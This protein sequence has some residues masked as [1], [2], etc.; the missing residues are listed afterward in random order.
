VPAGVT[1]DPRKAVVR[2]TAFDEAL[3]RAFLHRALKIR[4][5]RAALRRGAA[6]IATADS[7]AD[8]GRGIRRLAA[9]HCCLACKL[10]FV[11]V[12]ALLPSRRKRTEHGCAAPQRGTRDH[13][14][15]QV[16]GR[17]QKDVEE[18]MC[19]SSVPAASGWTRQKAA[20]GLRVVTHQ[21]A[22]CACDAAEGGP[23]AGPGRDKCGI[24][25]NAANS[26]IILQD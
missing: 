3:D 20:V 15:I 24:E 6:R 16:N 9:A 11:V 7:P 22:G 25:K 8:C 21:P 23:L 14:R 10:A 1:V 12:C 4:P 2:V 26:W 13:D 18:Q 19:S 17:V 5:L